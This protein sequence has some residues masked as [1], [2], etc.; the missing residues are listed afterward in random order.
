MLDAF[1]DI[2]AR[3]LLLFERV[4]ALGSI[5]GAAR[6]LGLA[7]P[8]ASRWLADLETKVGQPL[9]RRTT[10]HV[11]L[12]ERG[13]AF[14]ERTRDILA[15]YAAARLVAYANAPAGTIRVSVPIPLG[16]LLAGEVIA[17]FRKDLPGVRLEV[18]L[19]NERVDLVR[20]N[21]DLL[22]RGGPL[23]NSDLIARRLANVPMWLYASKSLQDTPP[24][25]LNIIAAPGDAALLKR[26]HPELQSPAVLVDDRAALAEALAAGAGAGALPAFLGEPHRATG[27]LIRVDPRPLSTTAIHAIYLPAQRDDLRLRVLIDQLTTALKNTLNAVEIA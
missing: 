24:A 2:R 7:K 16:R 9:V 6:E 12:T 20:D 18:R 1:D 26:T 27:H 5:T 14:L 19:Q 3:D 22:I 25:Q 17:K 8:T 10:R 13:E 4:A 21:F 23:P 11:A 15:A